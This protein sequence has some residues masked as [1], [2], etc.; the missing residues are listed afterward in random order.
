MSKLIQCIKAHK[1]SLIEKDNLIAA[2]EIYRKEGKSVKEANVESVRDI[3]ADLESEWDDIINQIEIKLGEPGREPREWKGI[4]PRVEGERKVKPK[5]RAAKKKVPVVEKTVPE[6]I[7]PK[8]EPKKEIVTEKAK[9]IEPAKIETP[10][11]ERRIRK[12]PKLITPEQIKAMKA[13]GYDDDYIVIT[14][15]RDAAYIIETGRKPGEVDVSK[16]IKGKPIEYNVYHG[17]ANWKGEFLGKP[18][19][20]TGQADT[21]FGLMFTSDP[22]YATDAIN[23]GVSEEAK[24]GHV[25]AAKVTLKNPYIIR[26]PDLEG[27]ILTDMLMREIP[28]G[29]I[30]EKDVDKTI[31]GKS[32]LTQVDGKYYSGL[33]ARDH[34]ISQ[35]YDGIVVNNYA[36]GQ[37]R[38]KNPYWVIPFDQSR[39]VSIASVK[40]HI[41]IQARKGDFFS[42]KDINPYFGEDEANIFGKKAPVEKKISVKENLLINPRTDGLVWLGDV[43][44]NSLGSFKTAE[45]A[46]AWAI[47]NGYGIAAGSPLKAKPKITKKP[48][49][50]TTEK[51]DLSSIT[52]DD[53][54]SLKFTHRGAVIQ[55]KDG[56][57][58]VSFPN[59]RGFYV[60]SINLVGDESIAI[61]TAYGR[62]AKLG[63]KIVG[64]YEHKTRTI[65]LIKG[66]GDKWTIAHEFQH[67]LEAS[68]LLT[69]DEI[70][71]LER[72]AVPFNKGKYHGEEG[73][74]RW[75]AHELEA[76]EKQRASIIGKIIQKI[77]DIIDS[78]VNLATQTSR[79]AIRAIESGRAV[80][81]E[82]G[83]IDLKTTVPAYEI[84]AQRWYS[85]MEQFLSDKLPG[86]GTGT[87]LLTTVDSWAKKGLI[88]Q[89]ELD[90]SGLKAYLATHENVT[91]QEVLD[92]LKENNV[93][94]K[95]IEKGDK[96]R[97]NATKKI[98]IKW[99]EGTVRKG[100]VDSGYKTIKRWTAPDP[101]GG[102]AI[103]EIYERLR[104]EE[105]GVMALDG[106]T[107]PSYKSYFDG[108]PYGFYSTLQNA[109]DFFSEVYNDEKGW[110]RYAPPE[111]SAKFSAHQL[112]GGKNYREL[113]L[114]MPPKDAKSK[115]Q[116]EFFP[117]TGSQLYRS[118]HWDE[119]N[120]L[121]HIRFNE[122]TGPNGERILFIE[123]VQ[124]DWHQKGRKEGYKSNR[125]AELLAK[126]K[127][128]KL[129]KAEDLELEQ[130]ALD[131]KNKIA[132]VPDAPFKKTWPLLAIKRM[133]RYAAENGYDSI[134]WTPGE[135]QAERYDLSKQI[136]E[137][138][139]IKHKDGTVYLGIYKG[140]SEIGQ[141]A[142]IPDSV[143]EKDIE[144]Y[145]GKEVAQKIIDGADKGKLS[146][147]DL[148][149]GGEGMKGFYDKI[150][151]AEV[152]RF[153]NKAAWGNAKVGTVSID[154]KES[155]MM[156]TWDNYV[157]AQG[158]NVDGL[159][160]A[161]EAQLIKEYEAQLKKKTII[162]VHNLLIT[163]EMKSK[164]LREGMPQFATQE[165]K[166]KY[167][168]DI[169]TAGTALF[170]TRAEFTPSQRAFLEKHNRLQAENFNRNAMRNANS[171]SDLNRIDSAKAVLV[172]EHRKFMRFIVDRYH[173]VLK[174]QEKLVNMSEAIDLYMKESNR[175]KVTSAKLK[176][177]WD[178]DVTPLLK[179][180]AAN[181]V[182][183]P[184]IEEYAHALHAREANTHLRTANSKRFYDLIV[185]ALPK[186]EKSAVMLENTGIKHPDEYEQALSAA[187]SEYSRI[188]DIKEIAAQWAEFSERPSGMTD[189]EA[190]EILKAYRDD[191]NIVRIG[192]ELLAIN[193]KTLDTLYESGA[194][195]EESYDNMRAKYK[196]YVPL[197][198]EGY[199]D[200]PLHGSGKGLSLLGRPVKTRMGSIR[201]VINILANSVSNLERAINIAEKTESA[202]VFLSLVQANPNRDIW[203]IKSEK[204]TP[205]YDDYGNLKL[206]PD[207]T[208]VTT[209]Q[210][211]IM[212][213][214]KQYLIE[215]SKADKDAMRML[216]TFKAEDAQHGFVIRGLS[217][218]NR[219]LSMV[220]TSW[221]PEFIITNLP[222]DFQ[223]AIINVS[224]TGLKPQNMFSGTLQSIR[225]IWNV[226]RG[227]RTKSAQEAMYDRFRAAGGKIGWSNAHS[228][229]KGLADNI[230]RDLKI[231]S[232]KA[233]ARKTIL[234]WMKLI[235]DANTSIENGVRL[236]IFKLAIQAGMTDAKAASIA[237]DITV[238]F[239][240]KGAAGPAINAF[241][242]FANAGIQG[243]Y[244]IFRAAK[245]SPKVRKMLGGIV[246]AGFLSGLMNVAIG[247][248]DEDGQDYFNKLIDS[249]A[250]LLE[251]NAVFL[252]PGGKGKHVK[253]PLPWGYNFIWNLG[254]EA[255]RA[256]TKTKY[257]PL[258][259][260]GRL[261]SVFANAFNPIAAG[262]LA[263]MI[264][265]TVIDPIAQVA[266]N[267]NW[268]GGDL[269]P[270]ENV[271]EK[272][273]TPDSQKY[274]KS[275]RPW[276]KWITDQMNDLTGG[277][278]VRPGVIDV[279]PETIDLLIDT[280]GGSALRFFQDSVS[281]PYKYI[282]GEQ[283]AIH[284][285][286]LVRRVVGEVSEGVDAKIYYNNSTQ[287]FVAE[288]ELKAYKGSEYYDILREK[289]RPEIRIISF[290]K[291][292]EGKLSKLRRERNKYEAAGN[293]EI[294]DK[295]DSKILKFQ[296]LYN[297]KFNEI[298]KQ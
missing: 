92:Y 208:N 263:Q 260:A 18:G 197:Y 256:F 152:N 105:D 112:P 56:S 217:K 298:M 8:V 128:G 72:Q 237:S 271:F 127:S 270:G 15:P 94:V 34:L 198:R 82:V 267:K 297:K 117:K 254:V 50:A 212:A 184:E 186:T 99:V 156:D 106:T 239:T 282:R 42:G 167:E 45:D 193:R 252:Y 135:V 240:K 190:A 205:V 40:E 70:D 200:E 222:R 199:E 178:E 48:V 142:G 35:G 65:R 257:D 31:Y 73:R 21:V 88:K 272:V 153:F 147:L 100:S 84:T 250:F 22:V 289:L 266:E 175:S 207:R 119:P 9:P 28:E 165:E 182:S 81:R 85:Q 177:A 170:A 53:L 192:A 69:K 144:N 287:V 291:D 253:I 23:F 107:G 248:D 203:T 261:I 276:S 268:F 26:A 58:S 19:I 83:G 52:L 41:P 49:L 191:K 249:Q 295:I 181:N 275:V 246:M 169:K 176:D 202:K 39:S 269:M 79:G 6:K 145:V 255:S 149:V 14:S 132:T 241:Y 66:R 210:I 151:P 247:G 183:L 164:A 78:F 71:A 104:P 281:T 55:N 274:W 62:P 130:I 29:F 258:S 93:R 115:E 114:T 102:T 290:T 283:V 20:N 43:K 286:P 103:Y 232:G 245:S 30:K 87:S 133:V 54:K 296:K 64:H 96:E 146:G 226:E 294:A 4:K 68:G 125:E 46:Q 259:G 179:R 174:V 233:P 279:S 278:A 288:A 7:E 171:I 215:V 154:T 244:R 129:T 173:P 219:F 227:I 273:P 74:A 292:I 61:K 285:I 17:T 141:T 136:D 60:E 5:K 213:D 280:I 138:R 32:Y 1:L 139:Y 121:A 206:Y 194:I 109:K 204:K 86:K 168:A 209:N 160:D 189:K 16:R 98:D 101:F 111:K 196:Y 231:Y 218:L 137:I 91:K 157:T 97:I 140:G 63:E 211:R 120:V 201:N 223:T 57:F 150:L 51:P 230:E 243:T 235:E 110:Q 220:N 27:D 122:R 36:E 13:L 24:K 172:N 2:A 113:L 89:E 3:I 224:D 277:S 221:S 180:M 124:S 158:F 187:I 161:H 76:R 188:P 131:R 143:P 238:D 236:H 228:D 284:E 37:P 159:T 225:A 251:R 265:P 195:P 185:E 75:V 11:P 95:E 242:L 38:G 148:K 59:N 118:A 214:G 108:S 155:P 264:A 44:G 126:E 67:F 116:Y 10:I 234:S 166:A 25:I 90:W 12:F 77:Q 123:E 134:A 162:P 163:S 262:S 47:E 229:I 33:K 80:T 216:K 293:K